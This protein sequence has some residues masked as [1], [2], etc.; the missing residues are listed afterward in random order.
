MAIC[1]GVSA[2][3][4]VPFL[5]TYNP[6]PK[7]IH[8]GGLSLGASFQSVTG[9]AM[10]FGSPY[11]MR[12]RIDSIIT[13]FWPIIAPIVPNYYAQFLCAVEMTLKWSFF[14]TILSMFQREQNPIMPH[15]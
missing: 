2:I 10:V 12:S 5:Q 7:S 15:S 9:F 13:S 4:I 14:S 11:F 1:S 3:Q 6:L 8:S